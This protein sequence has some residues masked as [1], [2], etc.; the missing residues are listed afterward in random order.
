MTVPPCCPRVL[1]YGDLVKIQALLLYRWK[2]S[3]EGRDMHD[4]SRMSRRIIDLR[5]V[6]W[7]YR[8]PEQRAGMHM[9]KVLRKGNSCVRLGSLI[10]VGAAAKWMLRMKLVSLPTLAFSGLHRAYF[11]CNGSWYT[12]NWLRRRR[13][14]FSTSKVHRSSKVNFTSPKFGRR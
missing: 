10:H 11:A 9:N 12:A 4:G 5:M 14:A 1:S 7:S 6:F 13:E 2:R 3:V 8:I